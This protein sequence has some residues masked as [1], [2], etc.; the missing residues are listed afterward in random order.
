VQERKTIDK[1]CI[2]E[3]HRRQWSQAVMPPTLNN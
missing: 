1:V 3:Q 2:I